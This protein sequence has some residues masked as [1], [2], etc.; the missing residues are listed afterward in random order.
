MSEWGGAGN[1]V[2]SVGTLARVE[3][4]GALP[5]VERGRHGSGLGVEEITERERAGWSFRKTRISEQF[6]FADAKAVLPDEADMLLLL[7]K[8]G[9]L[10]FFTHAT[11]PTPQPGDVIVSYAP[12]R[13]REPETRNENMIGEER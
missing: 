7:R 13:V 5:V 9:T 4:E 11:R 6:D 8:N 1:Q 12:P 3:G 2:L 10:R